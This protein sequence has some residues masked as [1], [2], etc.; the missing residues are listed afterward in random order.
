MKKMWIDPPS[1]WQYGFP[2]LYDT[3]IPL[4]E[5]L[6]DSGYPQKDVNFALQYLRTWP[7]VDNETV[8]KGI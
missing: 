6:V 4:E 5:W 3:N 2:K 7:E 1:G 8:V